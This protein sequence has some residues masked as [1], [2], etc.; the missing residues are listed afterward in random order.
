MEGRAIAR[1]NRPS[2][3]VPRSA[4][5]RLQWRAGQLPGRTSNTVSVAR[6]GRRASME[7]RAIA[8]PNAWPTRP[9]R[10][11][12]RRFNGGPGN[13]PAEPDMWACA[14]TASGCF[15]GGPGNC[16]AEPPGRRRAGPSSWC[17]SMEGRA[18]A[19]PNQPPNRTGDQSPT[20]FNGGPGNCPAE[21]PSKTPAAPGESASMEGRAIARP[22]AFRR[23][24]GA[25]TSSLQ[26]RAGQLPGRT[27]SAGFTANAHENLLQW[28]AGQLPGRTCKPGRCRC[29]SCQHAS[30]EG[31]AIARPN[32]SLDLG[33]LTCWFVGACERSRKLKLRTCSEC[34]IKLRFALCY[35]A[36]SGPRDLRAH[37]SAR[38]R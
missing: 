20:S 10:Y 32:C 31:R 25:A 2:R 29:R 11:P 12:P 21:L 33:C 1:P 3:V 22:N 34:V 16:P 26:W 35:K 36:S 19:R 38:I 23:T 18:I 28:R 13:C 24:R 27:C 17:A 8:R 4:A 37:R 14:A 7:G 30:M 6:W 9:R 5:C 15:N